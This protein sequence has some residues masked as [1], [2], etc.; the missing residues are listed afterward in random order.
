M[1][2]VTLGSITTMAD[3]TLGS[4][5]YYCRKAW[6]LHP[7]LTH[8]EKYIVLYSTAQVE[9]FCVI[10]RDFVWVKQSTPSRYLRPL[11]FLGA[12]TFF[13]IPHKF[14]LPFIRLF[15]NNSYLCTCQSSTERRQDI[16]GILNIRIQF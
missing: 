4:V 3:V 9:N 1:A 16:E 5:T 13:C 6:K 11:D 8:F 7:L 14:F 10:L 12:W 15:G 2:D